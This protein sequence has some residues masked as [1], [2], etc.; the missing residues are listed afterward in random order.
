MRVVFLLLCIVYLSG[1]NN[2]QVQLDDNRSNH[3]PEGETHSRDID[4][5]DLLKK[6]KLGSPISEVTSTINPVA[7]A[8]GTV[9]WG[10]TGA[11]RIYFQIRS[12]KQ[13]WF[14]LSGPG[15]GDCVTEI[16]QIESKSEWI[17]HDN[18]SITVEDLNNI[19]IGY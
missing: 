8:S 1:C 7:L 12:D 10:G 11:R 13:I 5:E 2:D 6:I 4:I 17:W 19:D 3:L 15:D 16:G 18:D 9:Y 14:E